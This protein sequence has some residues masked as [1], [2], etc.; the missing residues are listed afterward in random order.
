M[1]STCLKTIP[2][3][4]LQNVKMKYVKIVINDTII[5]DDIN[6]TYICI[7]FPENIKNFRNN[8]YIASTI[9]INRFD[10]T[11]KNNNN[12]EYSYGIELNNF[13]IINNFKK[14]NFNFKNFI[15]NNKFV[16][17]YKNKNFKFY[18]PFS[19]QSI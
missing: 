4:E 17:D 10:G 2:N 3:F 19:Q 1:F 14:I 8:N 15:K 13:K 7:Y 18:I 9:Y 11:I 16:I 5:I 6:E 12:N